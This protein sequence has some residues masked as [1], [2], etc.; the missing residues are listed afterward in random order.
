VRDL[1]NIFKALG[2]ET[3]LRIV[4]YLMKNGTHC[5]LEVAAALE[6]SQTRTSRNLGI[7]RDVGILRDERRGACIDYSIDFIR[8][9]TFGGCLKSALKEAFE[10]NL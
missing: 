3:R 1:E 6:L 10:I 9:G 7:L 4:E 8:L 2:D 5:V